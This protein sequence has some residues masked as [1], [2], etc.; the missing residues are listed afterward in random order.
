[1]TKFLFEETR[2]CFAYGQFLAAIV[3]GLSYIEHTVAAMFY[4]MGRDDLQK[5]SVTEL[6]RE[7]VRDGWIERTEFKALE[8]ARKLRNTVTHFRRPLRKDTVESR[9]VVKN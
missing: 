7:A 2:Y 3:L 5:S 4:A 8:R 1:M 6:L 9:A